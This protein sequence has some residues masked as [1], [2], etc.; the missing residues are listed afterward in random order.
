MGQDPGPYTN[1]KMS[2]TETFM[3]LGFL[4]VDVIM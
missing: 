2:R 3:L 4:M 1:E